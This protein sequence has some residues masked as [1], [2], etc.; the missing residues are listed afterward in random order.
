[1]I[2]AFLLVRREWRLNGCCQSKT[3]SKHAYTSDSYC[4]FPSL[5]LCGLP[6][7]L[8]EDRLIES[9]LAPRRSRGDSALRLSATQAPPTPSQPPHSLF[10]VPTRIEQRHYGPLE[11]LERLAHEQD[12]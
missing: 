10:A 5:S 12:V 11:R 2:S 4:R 1:M 8:C 9:S 7:E 6:P 3:V